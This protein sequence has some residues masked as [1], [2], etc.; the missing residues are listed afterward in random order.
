M[1]LIVDTNVPVVANGRKS[2]HA[3]SRCMNTCITELR[4]IQR[5]HTLV[6]DQGWLVL[7]EYLRNL[8]STGRPGGGDEFML[9]VL[10]NRNNP[11][12]CEFVTITPLSGSDDGNDFAEFPT[13]LALTNF[14]RADRKFV[15]ISLAHPEKPL[16]LNATDTDW[17]HHLFVL[18]KHG[19]PI[20]FLCPDAMP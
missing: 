14:D 19:V 16:I 18:E 2:E 20:K 6:L 3:S 1:K 8:S 12:H 11:L 9:W 4:D 17:W 5:N 13:D 7:R 10:Q 15:A